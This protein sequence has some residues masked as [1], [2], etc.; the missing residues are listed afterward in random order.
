M[1]PLK[2]KIEERPKRKRHDTAQ[3]EST[4]TAGNRTGSSAK[5]VQA[6]PTG[7]RGGERGK[8]RVYFFGCPARSDNAKREEA[9]SLRRRNGERKMLGCSPRGGGGAVTHPLIE[10]MRRRLFHSPPPTGRMATTAI[11]K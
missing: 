7:K 3:P 2:I 10:E 1:E 6:G 5:G 8:L 11:G 4:V 9:I